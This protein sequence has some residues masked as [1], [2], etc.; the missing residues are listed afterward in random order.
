MDM[1]GQLQ[2][3]LMGLATTRAPTQQANVENALI[4]VLVTEVSL[5][6]GV[7]LVI[8]LLILVGLQKLDLVQPAALLDVQGALVVAAA[9]ATSGQIHTESGP[10]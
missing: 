7:G 10:I 3:D 4:V 8:D 6:D 2:S 1:D 9:L 5:D